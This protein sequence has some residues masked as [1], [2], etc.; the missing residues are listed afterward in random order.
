MIVPSNNKKKEKE[1]ILREFH[2]DSVK[3]ASIC[4]IEP[5][6]WQKLNKTKTKM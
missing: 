6:E 2:F 5:N 3:V 4:D 1:K